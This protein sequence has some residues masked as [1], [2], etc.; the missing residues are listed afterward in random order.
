MHIGSFYSGGFVNLNLM[1]SLNHI[2]IVAWLFS[3]MYNV[4]IGSLLPSPPQITSIYRSLRLYSAT[5][6]TEHS[7]MY[8]TVLHKYTLYSSEY[9][10]VKNIFTWYST[11]WALHANGPWR[12]A[13][14]QCRSWWIYPGRGTRPP[15]P[16]WC[17]PP[18]CSGSP[19]SPSR[20][21][22]VKHY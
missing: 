7:N 20:S 19:A 16:S 3:N 15:A 10:I 11:W 12:L 5:S 18:G 2:E 6:N 4:C 13:H 9:E 21:S 14:W 1:G 17:P 8:R 22:P